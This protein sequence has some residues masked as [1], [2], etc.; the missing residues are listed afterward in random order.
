MKPLSHY[1]TE[2]KQTYDFKIK[3]A[4]IEI[5][6]DV[7]D[8]IEHALNSFEV[9]NL[10]KPKRLPIKSQNLDFPSLQNC[11]VSLIIASLNYPCTDEQV[12]QA[13]SKQA[14]LPLASI[15]VTPKDQPEELLRDASAEDETTDK[16]KAAI[17]TKELEHTS[18]GQIQVGAKRVESLLKE[19]ETQRNADKKGK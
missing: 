3:I 4:S 12:R 9:S 2:S 17:L 11:E 7:L 15:V 5:N 1:L 13:I 19:L 6:N 10:S 8:R 18:G 16:N 14:M